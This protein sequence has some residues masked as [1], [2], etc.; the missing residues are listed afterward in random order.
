[1]LSTCMSF[2]NELRWSV[3]LLLGGFNV[4]K[5]L[6]SFGVL[7]TLRIYSATTSSCKWQN[8]PLN[9][10]IL[11][12]ESFSSPS[13]LFPWVALTS[14]VS[15]QSEHT[16]IFFQAFVQTETQHFR[17]MYWAEKEKNFSLQFATRNWNRIELDHWNSIDPDAFKCIRNLDSMVHRN[18]LNGRDRQ[19]GK[20]HSSSGRLIG[21]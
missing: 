15:L 4:S 10:I 7:E 13:V 2:A 21:D 1:M 17:Q 12:N 3:E 20:G 6:L 9:K 16:S 8:H 11:S 5:T 18:S 19:E 14:L